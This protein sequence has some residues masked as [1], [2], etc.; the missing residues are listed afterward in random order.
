[1][2][3]FLRGLPTQVGYVYSSSLRKAVRERTSRSRYDVV[4]I[5]LGRMVS[6]L[7]T[8]RAT[9]VVVDLVDSLSLNAAMR[10]EVGSLL[11]RPFWR[12]EA[13]RMHRVEKW[14]VKAAD[15]SVVV[16]ERDRSYIDGANEWDIRVIPNGVDLER[17]PVVLENREDN[18]ILFFGN[19]SYFANVDAAEYLVKGVL[20]IIAARRKDVR[21]SIVGANPGRAVRRLAGRGVEVTGWVPSMMPY[22]RRATVA[23]FPFRVAT[24]IQNKVLEAM[25]SGLPVVTTPTVAEAVK[26]RDGQHL[27]VRS[28]TQGLAEAVLALM[29]NETMRRQIAIQARKF[30]ETEYRWETMVDRFEALL[31][32]V[33]SKSSLQKTRGAL[34]N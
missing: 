14:I 4:V 34:G 25:A 1:M 28:T 15:A 12:V 31:A 17:Y 16:S 7:D 18:H 9:P 32:E 24:G 3:S 2:V 6:Y 23:V 29:G 21:T 20:P 10:A 5:Q 22:L 33:V 19:M 8:V 27:L 13:Q 11:A 30:V 26:A